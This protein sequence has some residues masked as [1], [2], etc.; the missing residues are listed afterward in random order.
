MHLLG[1][2]ARRNLNDPD[3]LRGEA[4][5]AQIGCAKCHIPE[6]KTSKLAPLAELRDQTIHPYTDLLLHDMGPGLADN[7]G[8]ARATG[9]EWR[10]TPLWG[11][12]LSACVTGGVV[13]PLQKQVCTPHHDYLHDG[14]A[15]SFEE[16]IRW[17]GGEG[18]RSKDAYVALSAADRAAVTRF[19]ESL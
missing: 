13:G 8:E 15:R 10:T 14:R 11:I 18:Q 5:F 7:L 17:H 1:V 2:P 12:G 16:A 19:L 3:A 9:A 4:L 6:L